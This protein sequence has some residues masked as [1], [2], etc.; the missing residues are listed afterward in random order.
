MNWRLLNSLKEVLLISSQLDTFES[1][2]VDG[3]GD[4][5]SCPY[6]NTKVKILAWMMTHHLRPAV[7]AI[8]KLRVLLGR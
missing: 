8:D 7:V 6:I 4:I 3:S 5:W 1:F 2:Y